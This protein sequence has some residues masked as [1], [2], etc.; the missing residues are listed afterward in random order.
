MPAPGPLPSSGIPS[1]EQIGLFL[2]LA[3]G[4]ALFLFMA[5]FLFLPVLILSPSKFALSFTIGCCLIFSAFAALK[6]WR[7]Q[8]AAMLAA[9]EATGHMAYGGVGLAM[10]T[11]MDVG[12]LGAGGAG[13][14]FE[15]GGKRPRVDG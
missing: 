1:T 3:G 12:A 13:G 7:R 2:A 10:D 6:G 5:F 15:G 8:A 11:H 9:V 4:G 14:E